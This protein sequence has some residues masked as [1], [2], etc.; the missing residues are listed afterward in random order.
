[1]PPD[2]PERPL[3]TLIGLE[4]LVVGGV[5]LEAEMEIGVACGLIRSTHANITTAHLVVH[6][7]RSCKR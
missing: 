7:C 6:G 5:N 2:F 4:T 1:M 3:Q